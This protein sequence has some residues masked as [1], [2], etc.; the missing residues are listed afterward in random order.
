MCSRVGSVTGAF[1]GKQVWTRA[2]ERAPGGA[3]SPRSGSGRRW[4]LSGE[5]RC[6]ELWCEIAARRLGRMLAA[7]GPFPGLPTRT[8]PKALSRTLPFCDVFSRQVSRVSAPRRGRSVPRG[9]GG[10]G[11]GRGRGG[12]GRPCCLEAAE[13]RAGA[14]GTP[15][16]L[17]K[18]RRRPRSQV[19][20]AGRRASGAGPSGPRNRG[21]GGGGRGQASAGGERLYP[22]W[23]GSVSSS[24]APRD[25]WVPGMSEVAPACG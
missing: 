17:L 6:L 20:G 11:T 3:S 24:K 25:R 8:P 19:C 4:L 22:C 12:G 10:A 21:A 2:W 14:A 13:P 7:S 18:G 15:G 16:S 1:G 9:A 23:V 5:V